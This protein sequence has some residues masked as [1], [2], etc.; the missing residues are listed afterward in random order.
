MSRL[1]VGAPH[2]QR[3]RH[4]AGLSAKKLREHSPRH[5]LSEFYSDSVTR[6]R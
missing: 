5:N 4:I 1:I 2:P 3:D 6:A